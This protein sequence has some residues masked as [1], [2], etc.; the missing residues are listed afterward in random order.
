SVPLYIWD[1][2]AAALAGAGYRVLRYD[3]FGRGWSDRPRVEYTAELY[4]RQLNE[5][6]DSLGIRD[7]VDL[8]GVSMGGW[9]AATFAGR[10]ANRVRSLMLVDPVAGHSSPS[11]SSRLLSL[12]FVGNYIWQ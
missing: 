1:S 6:L 10:H 3:E 2:A 9:V 11:F 4:D 12:P 8:G 7:R 5:L